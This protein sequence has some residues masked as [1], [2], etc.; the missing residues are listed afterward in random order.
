MIHLVL[1]NLIS[2]A[3]KF[4][5]ARG[6]ISVGASELASFTEVY[7]QDSGNGIGQKEMKKIN[8]QEFYST[9]GTAS[10]QGTGLGLMLCKEFLVKNDG[11]LRIESEPGKGSIF[12]FT[13]PLS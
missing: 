3:I 12:S 5:P 2:N 11:C 13:L 9:N 10:E 6:N 7:V 4:T 1:R 8:N